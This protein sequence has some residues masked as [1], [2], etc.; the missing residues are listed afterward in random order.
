MDWGT[1]ISQWARTTRPGTLPALDDAARERGISL[2][3]TAAKG[4]I[5]WLNKESRGSTD[6]WNHASDKRYTP[7]HSH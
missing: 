4:V 3:A 2:S 1:G 7:Q 5:V 6:A